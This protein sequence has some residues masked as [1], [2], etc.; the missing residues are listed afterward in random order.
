MERAEPPLPRRGLVVALQA[1]FCRVAL[2]RPGPNGV[3]RLLCTRRTRMDKC[4][5]RICTGD[6]VLVEAIDWTAA[7]GVVASLEPRSNRLNRPSVANVDRIL[8]VVALGEPALDALQLTRF[9]VTAEGTGRPVELVLTKADLL[10][11]Q[12]VRQWCRRIATWGYPVQAISTRSGEGVE[13]LRHS[14]S[15]AGIAVLCGP[16]GVG[17]SSLLNCLVPELAL[18]VAAVSGRL[19]R[20]RHTTRHVELFPLG[21]GTLVADTPGFNQ[22]ELPAEP[23]ALAAA[24]PELRQRLAAAACRFRNCRHLGDP[25]CAAGTDWPRFALYSQCLAEVETRASAG[26]TSFRKE[27]QGGVRNRGGGEEPLL[28]GV[29]RRASRRRRRQELDGELSPPSPAGSD[30]DHP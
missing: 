22:P 23:S 12:E 6:R 26:T 19:Q 9:L 25:G 5:R 4:G 18:R 17:K 16:S 24:F 29:R 28:Q 21:E 1:N 15:H 14:L 7:R 27:R 3:G 2:E 10:P 30:P 8:V 13:D 20:G 11:Q